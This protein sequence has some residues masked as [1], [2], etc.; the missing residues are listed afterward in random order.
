LRAANA[1]ITQ[2]QRQ[3]SLA[4]QASGKLPNL[5][6]R[7][8]QP[9]CPAIPLL[10]LIIAQPAGSPRAAAGSSAR[11]QKPADR[12]PVMVVTVVGDVGR[13]WLSVAAL[14]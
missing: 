11:G 14:R 8:Y 4:L 12:E 5:I 9:T 6:G 7:P 1:E 10:L 2:T 3:R 13:P